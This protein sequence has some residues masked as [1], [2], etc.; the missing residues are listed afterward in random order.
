VK[1]LKGIG[2]IRLSGPQPKAFRCPARQGHYVNSTQCA[3]IEGKEP[4]TCVRLHCS[5]SILLTPRRS[6]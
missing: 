5:H 3:A 6:A 1:V 4:Q 2:V